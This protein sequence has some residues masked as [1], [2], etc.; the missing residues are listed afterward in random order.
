MDLSHL[1]RPSILCQCARCSSSVAACENEWAKLSDTYST[2]TGWVSID[3]N[4]INV[5]P[6]KKQIPHSSELEFVRGRTVQDIVCRLCRQKLGGLV[7]LETE[8]K[9]FWKLSKVSFREI[10]TMKESHPLFVGGS[11]SWLLEA[12]E[13]PVAQTDAE[14]SPSFSTG[15]RETALSQTLLNQGASLSRISSSVEELHDTMSDLKQSFKALRLELNT[16]TPSTRS[17]EYHGDEAMDMLR[18]VLKELQSKSD[19]IEKLKLENDSLKWR[20]KCLQEHQAGT[21]TLGPQVPELKALPQVQSPAFLAEAGTS[22]LPVA[23][24]QIPIADTFEEDNEIMDH[25]T[26]HEINPSSMAPVKVPLKPAANNPPASP[27]VA[28][29]EQVPG[30]GF[31]SRSRRGSGEPATKRLR[32]TRTEEIESPTSGSGASTSQP[33]KERKRGRPL[34]RRKSQQALP[35]EEPRTPSTEQALSNTNGADTG[36]EDNQSKAADAATTSENPRPR[37]RPRRA[38][39]RASPSG[40]TSQATSRAPSASSRVTRRA[41]KSQE[42]A[43]SRDNLTVQNPSRPAGFEVAVNVAELTPESVVNEHELITQ[44]GNQNLGPEPDDESLQ[45]QAKL[46]ARDLLAKTAM[47]REEAMDDG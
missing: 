19:E 6:E 1:S 24:T 36:T 26:D 38:R 5:S 13:Q 45:Y 37:G 40:S 23:A 43:K 2:L 28:A 25:T 21:N 14:G 33:V 20:N 31:V 32:L 44:K 16:T 3:M 22:G 10:I 42:A 4:R 35:T 15:R 27:A 9:V 41:R 18:T 46:A 17:Q 29:Q 30:P 39:S 7:H 12:V 47:E 11:L 8:A 34:G